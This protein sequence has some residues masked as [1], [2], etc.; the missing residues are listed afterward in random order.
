MIFAVIAVFAFDGYDA[1]YGYPALQSYYGEYDYIEHGYYPYST[2]SAYYGY[3][4]YYP[5]P[6]GDY[7]YLADGYEDY[8][9]IGYAPSYDGYSP[10]S[11]YYDFEFFESVGMLE[12]V[13]GGT[14]LHPEPTPNQYGIMPVTS[15]PAGATWLAL[16]AAINAPHIPTTPAN[17]PYHTVTYTITINATTITAPDGV[18]SIV[19]I[20]GR[21]ITLVSGLA[22][23]V[24]LIQNNAT[25][26]YNTGYRHLEIV[27]SRLTLDRITLTRSTPFSAGVG[28]GVVM[29]AG[30]GTPPATP[31]G[32]TLYMTGGS[33]IENSRQGSGGAIGAGRNSRI[34][35]RNAII[36]NTH[37]N[38][39]LGAVGVGGAIHGSGTPGLWVEM[40]APSQVYGNRATGTGGSFV[41]GNIENRSHP[42]NPRNPALGEAVF[43][44][45]GGSIHDSFAGMDGGGV[46][47]GVDG[48][49]YM[50][51]GTIRNNYAARRGG[52]V[53]IVEDS[54]FIW[55]GGSIIDN[56]RNQAGEIVTPRGGGLSV[57]GGGSVHISGD[58]PKVVSGN[59]SLIEGGGI[60]MSSVGPLG[61]N[62]SVLRVNYG[63]QVDIA[64][65]SNFIVQGNH[66]NG[67]GGGIYIENDSFVRD[68][69]TF[70]FGA[71]LIMNSGIVRNNSANT[72][73]GGI[74]LRER[75]GDPNMVVTL[76][77]NPSSIVE[78]NSS[79]TS[80]GGVSLYDRAH[81][82]IDGGIIRGNTA[83]L[84]G[85]GVR[86]DNAT[87]TMY[88][89]AIYN[90]RYANRDAAG[91]TSGVIPE[92]G[93]VWV[94]GQNGIFTMTGGTIGDP[95]PAHSNRALRG[96][97]VW[98]G[99]GARFYMEDRLDNS[100]NV[101]SPGVGQVI[102]NTATGTGPVGAGNP[103][104]GGGGVYV[105]GANSTFNFSAG[106]VDKN[107]ADQ[108]GGVMVAAGA[109]LNLSGT[110]VIDSNH[111]EARLTAAQWNNAQTGGG[112]GVMVLG[113][114]SPANSPTIFT[115]TGGRISRNTSTPQSGT[116]GGAGV[117]VASAHTGVLPAVYLSS[118]AIF[119][120][121]D[122]VI[123]GPDLTYAN[124]FLAASGAGAGVIVLS[125]TF[126][127]SGDAAIMFN[128][129]N[130][131]QHGGGI[132][133]SGP[134][135]NPYPG[136]Y[137]SHANVTLSGSAR[138]T[139]NDAGI[140]AGIRQ[141][142]GSGG[143]LTVKDNVL[144][145]Y[146]RTNNGGA[147]GGGVGVGGGRFYFQGGTIRNHSTPRGASGPVNPFVPFG[148]G[149]RQDGGVVIMTGGEIRDNQVG[150]DG[151]GIMVNAGRLYIRGGHIFRNT[152]AG[153]SNADGR[154][155][156]V[157]VNN[158]TATFTMTGGYIGRE[159]PY[160]L[161]P[162]G[163]NPNANAATTGGGAWVG[164]GA[165]FTMSKGN[166][167]GTP[168]IGTILG[169]IA[170]GDQAHQGG[171]G[172]YV[173]GGSGS[174]AS[175]A[176]SAFTINAGTI[177][178]GTR[179]HGNHAAI[180][181]GGV[182]VN[183][184]AVF[185]MEDEGIISRNTAGRD[186]TPAGTGTA[187]GGVRI[188]DNASVFTMNGG[189]IQYNV[190][191]GPQSDGGGVRLM[192]GRMYMY[193]GTIRAN[194]TT[195]NGGGVAV[196]NNTS[197]ISPTTFTMHGGVI[198]GPDDEDGNTANAMGGGIM[199]ASGTINMYE[200]IVEGNTAALDGGGINIGGIPRGSL[201][202]MSGSGAKIIRNNQARHGGG[203]NVGPDARF[204][205]EAG[206]IYGNTAV[207]NGG[208]VSVGDGGAFFMGDRE[209]DDNGTIIITPGTGRIEGNLATGTAANQGGGG[210]FVTGDTTAVTL[211]AGS[212]EAN[213]AHRGGGVMITGG[214]FNMRGGNISHN[215]YA[216]LPGSTILA[217][218]G[219]HIAGAA[220]RFNMYRGTLD[221]NE[222]ETGGGMHIQMGTFNLRGTYNKNITNNH[223]TFGGGVWVAEDGE[224]R[225]QASPA[226]S[227]VEIAH[228]T[229][230]QRGGG[231]FTEAAEYGN[232]LTRLTGPY[233]AYH[234]LY[235]R[236]VNFNSNRAGHREFSPIN[237]LDVMPRP[238]D[239]WVSL[240]VDIHPFNNY[241]INFI[242]WFD[243]P[244]T[245]GTGTYNIFIAPGSI[246]L[247]A[248]AVVIIIKKFSNKS[249]TGLTENGQA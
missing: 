25:N 145:A 11:P 238:V 92:G 162:G 69:V 50:H 233:R 196:G 181:G 187:G 123:G 82:I 175:F 164:G 74:A 30:G 217:G 5:Y 51:G 171:G 146:N 95:N 80:G 249:D 220:G 237:A 99:G 215:T 13:E 155:G 6:Q 23:N 214:D 193:D 17:T 130:N 201:L 160:G 135:Q 170:T 150:R 7:S 229:A 24:T 121:S 111:A 38:S 176:P 27:R 31:W 112:G 138:V 148:G 14:V 73:G 173:T 78:D 29:H 54:T 87:V 2:D 62:V 231:I 76:T 174:G 224:M 230:T 147:G 188:N 227:G 45:H 191:L 205:M 16:Q 221:N 57:L 184:G 1:G 209:Y 139:N 67:I 159:A 179:A 194:T 210:V 9:Y 235:L 8:G 129:T 110:A 103:N 165:T 152:A 63:T 53:E 225:M 182:H 102:G 106:S 200:G 195:R 4:P 242:R 115:M 142:T 169:N 28:G 119:N 198:G 15:L 118:T 208:G 186:D 127:M 114:G 141:H 32:A 203:V 157:F 185:T 68:V 46:R 126:N 43:T 83:V 85:G 116:S 52:G 98:V 75:S 136:V 232:P 84:S 91:V 244:L 47:V 49:F 161:A 247:G 219:V 48:Y 35:L 93:G 81:L 167:N 40:W 183:G 140:S 66:T 97:G 18:G 79:G 158:A 64:I 206:L 58:A 211:Q 234:N 100:G 212:I 36:R 113:Y 218:G 117:H 26:A 42:T 37:A 77:L 107:T 120:M 70:N 197:A 39:P 128:D 207:Q 44:M 105:V 192:H 213:R 72:Y 246:L 34:Y 90:N 216:I 178:G 223:A 137:T 104:H 153:T 65:G 154:G 189:L 22:G 241:D 12:R 180:A 177:G 168:T 144:I 41:I 131:T 59:Y 60:Y 151:A 109:H 172:V 3:S 134:V 71:S 21:N 199:V 89:G 156:G 163:A 204:E 108:G 33:V 240:S 20:D 149:I 132:W 236:G 228:N 248:V 166:V 133:M 56:G 125:A 202:I 226:A 19:V 190:A 143:I 61:Q 96:G 243:L 222:A 86:N 10:I 101:I 94:R 124:R 245:G 55:T 122:G 239:D 88:S